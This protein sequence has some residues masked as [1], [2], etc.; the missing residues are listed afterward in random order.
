MPSWLKDSTLISQPPPNSRQPPHISI[1]AVQ[2]RGALCTILERHVRDLICASAWQS[3]NALSSH[4][5]T[6][7]RS[8]SC[9]ET[10]SHIDLHFAMR[11]CTLSS[12]ATSTSIATVLKAIAT[13]QYALD[14]AIRA[15]MRM[16]QRALTLQENHHSP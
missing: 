5:K 11:L 14:T 3:N 1:W 16:A 8:S 6:K 13:E 4:S 2:T 12:S 15:K 9:R 10:G 7:R